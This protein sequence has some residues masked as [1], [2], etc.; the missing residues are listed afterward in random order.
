MPDSTSIP[1]PPPAQSTSAVEA[2]PHGEFQHAVL[3]IAAYR[4][5][6]QL[7][8]S[9]ITVGLVIILLSVVFCTILSLSG[10]TWRAIPQYMDALQISILGIFFAC[11]IFIVV[12]GILGLTLSMKIIMRLLAKNPFNKRAAELLATVPSVEMLERAR[13]VFDHFSTA[14]VKTSPDIIEFFCDDKG[15]SLYWRGLLLDN[16]LLLHGRYLADPQC[17]PHNLHF[18]FPGE[19]QIE[20]TGPEKGKKVKVSVVVG[21]QQYKGSMATDCLERYWAWK[22]KQS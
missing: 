7:S 6:R 8:L 14:P 4:N 17:S 11:I 10:V 20:E 13:K 2:L 9:G 19:F 15:S 3:Y 1:P 16:L 5:L 18:L 12:K 21:Y 22:E